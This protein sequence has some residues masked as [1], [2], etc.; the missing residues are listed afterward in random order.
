MKK[1]FA[2]LVVAVMLLSGIMAIPASAV[3][4]TVYTLDAQVNGDKVDV[5]VTVS[6]N[7][8]GVGALVAFLTFNKNAVA[9][10]ESSIKAAGVMD[11]TFAWDYTKHTIDV[12]KYTVDNEYKDYLYVS[13]LNQNGNNTNNGT[14][15]TVSFNI[16][17]KTENF[18]FKLELKDGSVNNHAHYDADNKAAATPFVFAIADGAATNGELP[19]TDAPETDAPVTDAPETDAPATD[20]PETDAPATDAP[21]TDAPETTKPVTSPQTGDSM[22]FVAVIAV[23]ALAACSTVVVIR[24]RSSK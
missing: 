8:E 22:I 12:S 21:V 5:T 14:L 16:L 13:Y 20:A 4:G 6:D 11:N 18:D 2:V 24:R 19:E 23:L 15:F 3:E 10:D 7:D 17:D 1:I 9:I